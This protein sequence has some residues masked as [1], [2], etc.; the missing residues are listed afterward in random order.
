MRSHCFQPQSRPK[1]SLCTFVLA[2][3]KG[4]E[5]ERESD[6]KLSLRSQEE[7]A[8]PR[9]LGQTAR[10]RKVCAHL[11]A[12]PQI[13]GGHHDLRAFPQDRNHPNLAALSA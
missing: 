13:R 8:H 3:Q 10:L 5:R 11:F 2:K 7:L 6:V 12:N 1:I 9:G 4:E